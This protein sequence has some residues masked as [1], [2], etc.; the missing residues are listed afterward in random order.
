MQT[1]KILLLSEGGVGKT[2]FTKV[3]AG[4][5]YDKKYIAT[6]GVEVTPIH[7]AN[8]V[9]NIWDCAG[10][11]KFSGLGDGYYVHSHGAIFAFDLTSFYTLKSL[12]KWILQCKRICGDIPFVIVGMKSDCVNIIP[13][14]DIAD[15][16]GETPYVEISSKNGENI[17][18]PLR[19]LGELLNVT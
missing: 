5:E 9:A 18:E 16:I 15:I 17:H 14:E 8:F 1:F 4:Q 13:L 12:G 3:L 2:I 7:T 11:E 6:L 19:I 10:Q